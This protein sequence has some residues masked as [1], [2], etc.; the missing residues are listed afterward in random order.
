MKYMII[1]WSVATALYVV[2]L[3]IAIV[4]PNFTALMGWSVATLLGIDI[5]DSCLK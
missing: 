1:L 2:N 3:V 4:N 5:I